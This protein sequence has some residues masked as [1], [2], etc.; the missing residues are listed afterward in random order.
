[1]NELTNRVLGALGTYRYANL[2]TKYPSKRFVF[3]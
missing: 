1:M 3:V 2:E